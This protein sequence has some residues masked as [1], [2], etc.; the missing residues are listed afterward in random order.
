[1]AGEGRVRGEA[2]R[3]PCPRQPGRRCTRC[4]PTST[5]GASGRRGRTSI[6]TMKPHLRRAPTPA[7]GAVYEWSGNR[8]AGA[9]R[10]EITGA[11]AS[12]A[13]L[14]IALQFLKP[15]KSS[16]TTTFERRPE[17]RRRHARH[18]AHG[19]AQ[20]VHDTH[21]GRVH[22]HGQDGGQ[23]LREG[24]RPP[25]GRRHHVGLNPPRR[26]IVPW[27]YA[28]RVSRSAM[29][30]GAQRHE[31]ADVRRERGAVA[32]GVVEG[33]AHVGEVEVLDADR[34]L[35][36]EP[37]ELGEHRGEVDVAAVVGV[38]LRVDPSP[39][40]AAARGR[41]GAGPRPGPRPRWRRGRCRR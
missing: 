20:D 18:L 40:G 21:D 31:R 37:V 13:R 32:D 34:A 27:Y 22:E 10:M 3:R 9:G 16:N 17:R 6:P 8:K 33:P 7:A 35:V 28:L 4:S 15:F 41:R 5:A 36:V 39:P 25:E 19:R 23:G 11:G 26:F 29:N 24:P 14:E 2:R 38:A 30:R 1:M 12:P